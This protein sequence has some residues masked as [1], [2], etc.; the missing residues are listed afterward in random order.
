M[1]Q[2]M[3][4]RVNSTERKTIPV[5][6]I[7]VEIF[8]GTPR[9][10]NV[11]LNFN[12]TGFPKTAAVVLEATCGGSEIVQRFECGSIGNFAQEQKFFLDKLSGE[13]VR[14]TLKIVATSQ[15]IGRILGFAENIRPINAG[16]KDPEGKQGILPIEPSDQ[17]GEQ[18]WRLDFRNNND[19]VFL[20]VNNTLDEELPK[21]FA[22]EQAI[23]SLIYPTI[24]REILHR[25]FREEGDDTDD[26]GGWKTTWIRFA[27][28]FNPDPPPI[29]EEC[30]NF[31]SWSNVESWIEEAVGKF[32]ELHR[33]NKHYPK[34]TNTGELS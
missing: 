19:D 31:E 4:R 22:T 20:L 9:T 27:K 2:R 12:K 25:A 14:F 21:R 7:R 10:V 8:D 23:I 6:L 1:T 33:F 17:L 13:N 30:S 11:D 28:K 18:L 24:V 15:E 5:S 26:Q 34:N 16:K 32:S 29:V 3:V